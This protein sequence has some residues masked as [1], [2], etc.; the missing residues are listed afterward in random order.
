MCISGIYIYIYALTVFNTRCIKALYIPYTGGLSIPGLKLCLPLWS[1]TKVGWTNR[2]MGKLQ[3]IDLF[4]PPPSPGCHDT[5]IGPCTVNGDGETTTPNPHSWNLRAN[6]IWVDQ[7][8]GVGFSYGKTPRDFDHG[9]EG[10]AED[11][12]W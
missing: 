5:M 7:P 12:F 11:M 8:A 10:V 6:V 4:T 3:N 9:E 2:S 1:T